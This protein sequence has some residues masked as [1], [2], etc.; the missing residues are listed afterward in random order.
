MERE[1]REPEVERGR[2]RRWLPVLGATVAAVLLVVL[3]VDLACGDDSDEGERKSRRPEIVRLQNED[4]VSLPSLAIPRLEL[5]GGHDIAEGQFLTTDRP[6]APEG[7]L[8][9]ALSASQVSTTEDGDEETT[10]EP[11]PPRSSKPS[12]RG[13]WW[14]APPTS[15]P[16]APA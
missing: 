13:R 15:K 3:V 1:L 9:E 11:D 6:N 12:P 14:P 4:V 7:F 2:R 10:V 5:A 16:R 8:L